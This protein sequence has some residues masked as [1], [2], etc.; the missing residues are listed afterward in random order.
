VLSSLREKRYERPLEHS[1]RDGLVEDGGPDKAGV[2]ASLSA[3]GAEHE[4]EVIT[5]DAR[6]I[7][8]AARPPGLQISSK[9]GCSLADILASWR[10][11]LDFLNGPLG[12]L[13]MLRLE[14]GKFTVQF[15]EFF[16]G[17]VL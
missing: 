10:C 16:V 11:A 1:D 4:G 5:A 2:D 13:P 6:C 7:S 3:A 9:R 15:L 12:T 17:E 14:R 8:M